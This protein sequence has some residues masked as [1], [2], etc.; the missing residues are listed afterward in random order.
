V[1]CT[2][3]A[4]LA[5]A[6]VLSSGCLVVS[7]QPAYDADSVVFDEALLGQW[8]N[9]DDGAKATVDRGEW[10]SYKV[11]YVDRFATRSFQGNITKIGTLT[12]LDLTEMRGV[13]P[14]PYLVPV[15]AV[16]RIAI[17]GAT[18]TAEPLDYAWFMRAIAEKTMTRLAVAVDDRRNAV[19]AAPTA[20]LRRWLTS[21]PED[22]F[23]TPVTFTRV[24]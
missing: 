4:S 7:L 21:P 17:D 16:W 6:A 10:R 3:A 18:L 14:G 19:I 12:Y 11:T 2:A 5:I 9:R 8:Q 20:D 15:H 23:D 13:D 1:R 24:K 22:A